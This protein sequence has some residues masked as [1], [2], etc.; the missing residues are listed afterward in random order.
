VDNW[1]LLEVIEAQQQQGH[2]EQDGICI[3]LSH[4]AAGSS[5]LILEDFVLSPTQLTLHMDHRLGEGGQAQVVRGTLHAPPFAVHLPVA[6]KRFPF[7]AGHASGMPLA[8][9]KEV[10]GDAHGTAGF[11][12]SEQ[13]LAPLTAYMPLPRLTSSDCHAPLQIAAVLS[14]AASGAMSSSR[15]CKYYGVCE[16]DGAVCL[17]MHL[18]ETGSLADITP[19]GEQVVLISCSQPC[20]QCSQPACLLEPLCMNW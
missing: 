12:P 1:Q 8:F 16:K 15:L 20:A 11:G 13:Q 2:G 9:A 4:L 3:L 19:Q 5:H 17:V 7:I 14:S 18:Y 10:G 6:V